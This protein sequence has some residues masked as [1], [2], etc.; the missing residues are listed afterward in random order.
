[1]NDDLISSLQKCVQTTHI[2]KLEIDHGECVFRSSY[3][4]LGKVKDTIVDLDLDKNDFKFLAIIQRGV[5]ELVEELDTIADA[6]YDIK[7]AGVVRN[8]SDNEAD[9]YKRVNSK[10]Q[11]ASAEYQ[12]AQKSKS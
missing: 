6:L 10:I 7:K 1:M 5:F 3:G 12:Y 9:I 8:I 4:W 2:R 11:Q